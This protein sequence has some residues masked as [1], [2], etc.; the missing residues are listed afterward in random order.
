MAHH[1]FPDG[2]IWGAAT[3]AQQI[4]GGRHED[5]RGESIWDRFA[6]IPGKIEDG[7]NPDIACDHYHR[8]REDIGLMKWLGLGAYRFSIAWP[9]VMPAGRGAVNSAGLD[10]YDALVDGLLEAGIQPFPTLY[11]WDLPQV[12]QDQGGWDNRDTA[13]AFVE[14]SM[15][16][17]RRLGDRVRLSATGSADSGPSLDAF[18]AKAKFPIVKLIMTSTIIILV[19]DFIFC[20]FRL[21]G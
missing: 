18:W 4:E 16:V 21:R 20:S 15:A 13:E 14:Y 10:F 6:S 1:S 3:S 2:F 9:R 17:T 5:G 19:K 11:H 12:L 7:S 8:W